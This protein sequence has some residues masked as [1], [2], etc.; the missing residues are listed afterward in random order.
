MRQGQQ[1][2]RQRG[3][4]RKSQNPANRSYESNGPDVKIRGNASHV[5]E[6]YV[7]LAR[8]ALS[9]GDTI[10]GENYLQHAE[11]YFRI[12]S[13]NAQQA[14]ARAAQAEEDAART[15]GTADG[16]GDGV[17][18]TQRRRPRN[19]R[20]ERRPKPSDDAAVTD[21]AP[22]ARPEQDAAEQSGVDDQVK[23][24]PVK[25]AK[26]TGNGADKADKEVAEAAEQ[27]KIKDEP[28]PD[29]TA[30]AKAS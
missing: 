20:G 12:V 16:E 25:D 13:A 9:S 22:A 30:T 8:D 24:K 29:Q 18:G 3:R 7:N 27:A 23:D 11:H 10:S 17:Q 21:A 6:K 2:K 4:N 19:V 14:Q 5:A 1:N 26:T 15:D 28:K